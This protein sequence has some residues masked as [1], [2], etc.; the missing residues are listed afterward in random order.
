MRTILLVDD[1]WAIIEYCLR[2]L[3][4]VRDLCVLPAHSGEQAVKV[5]DEY[6]GT[7]QLLISDIAMPGMSG[8]Q[9]ANQLTASRPEIKT[10]LI[11]GLPPEGFELQPS[12]Q[13]L[14]KPFLP[15]D[16]IRQVETILANAAPASYSPAAL[17]PNSPLR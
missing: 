6:P 3:A 4:G 15:S 2:V 16:L 14:S 12:W 8:I 5:A 10:L 11:S 17:A 13:F 7:I 1:D 9:L